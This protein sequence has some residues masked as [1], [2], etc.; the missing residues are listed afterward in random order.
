MQANKKFEGNNCTVTVTFDKAE[1][2]GIYTKTLNKISRSA[3]IAGFR[4]GKAPLKMVENQYGKDTIF[5][6]AVNEIVNDAFTKG[7][8]ETGVE[9]L[10]QPKLDLKKCSMEEGAEMEFT[11]EAVPPVKVDKYKDLTVTYAAGKVDESLVE[12]DMNAFLERFATEETSEEASVSGNTVVIDFHGSDTDGNPIEKV[13]AHDYPVRLG[14]GGFI[15]GFEDALIGVKAGDKKEVTLKFPDDYR[16]TDLAGKDVK[17]AFTIK[18]VKKVVLPELTD[19]FV[20]EISGMESVEALKNDIRTHMENHTKEE[21]ETKAK[22]ALLDHI[23]ATVSDEPPAKMVDVEARKMLRDTMYRLMS[24][25]MK[26]EEL[27]QE[28]LL[29]EAQEPAKKKAK[30]KMILRSIADAENIKVEQADIDDELDRLAATYRI[31]RKEVVKR[32]SDSGS[33]D[34]LIDGLLANK[35]L[36]YIYMQNTVKGE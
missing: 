17:F 7:I 10:E 22:N 24:Y 19:E 16:E 26:P 34:M 3:K 14:K 29:A 25:G 6:E 27:K 18:D 20:K 2:E 33:T 31:K 36:D 35:V 11:G 15:A 28:E 30:S 8:S 21:N 4:P 13:H 5:S 12:K 23:A 1:V 9:F 32:L